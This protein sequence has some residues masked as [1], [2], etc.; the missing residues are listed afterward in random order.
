MKNLAPRLITF[1]AASLATCLSLAEVTTDCNRHLRAATEANDSAKVRL[2]VKAYEEGGCV[3]KPIPTQI[4]KA[5]VEGLAYMLY[6]QSKKR[7]DPPVSTV[8]PV[9]RPS[10]PGFG[11]GSTGSS[12]SH[13][14]DYLL[15]FHTPDAMSGGASSKPGQRSP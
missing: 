15:K 14:R 1:I 6:M 7:L 12:A 13:P 4:D 5:T 10:F 9:I 2:S 8:E 3:K 11:G